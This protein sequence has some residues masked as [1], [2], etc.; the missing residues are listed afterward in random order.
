MRMFFHR[1][2][3]KKQPA[4][5][6]MLT[7]DWGILYNTT[8]PVI[9]NLDFVVWCDAP[10]WVLVKPNDTLMTLP[11]MLKDPLQMQER[12]TLTKMQ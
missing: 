4:N 9:S 3:T 8:W 10:T 7:A 1:P 5:Q 6:S 12:K 2:V 11:K